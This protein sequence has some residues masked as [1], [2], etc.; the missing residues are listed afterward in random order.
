MTRDQPVIAEGVLYAPLTYWEEKAMLTQEEIENWDQY[1]DTE[2][3]DRYY[4]FDA[5]QDFTDTTAIYPKSQ[6]LA[7]LAMG[8]TSEAGEV[9]GKVKKFI[10]DG[11]LDEED[12]A[13]E[14]GDVLW[15]VAQLASHLDLYLSEV[16]QNNVDKLTDRKDRNTIGG[17][18]D[19]R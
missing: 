11:H 9:A 10:R 14:L 4:S 3:M 2:E 13:K 5:Y 19:D 15:Y 1:Q 17:S 16:A 12:L 8:L 7:Y 6:G 18:G